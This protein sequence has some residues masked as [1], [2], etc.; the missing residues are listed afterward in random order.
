MLRLT[1]PWCGAR[2]HSEFT[3]AGDATLKRPDPETGS[4][5]EWN[6]FVY[7]RDNPRGRHE[8]LWHHTNGCRQFIVVV[9]DTL[10]HEVLECKPATGAHGEAA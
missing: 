7:H 3:Y 2:D 8:E 4:L 5:D 6:A 1:C 10:T 9:R